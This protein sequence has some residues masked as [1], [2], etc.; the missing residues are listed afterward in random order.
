[1]KRFIVAALVGL[2]TAMVARP[3]AAQLQ[4]LPVYFNP[5]GGTGLTISGDFGRA[6][7][8]KVNDVAQTQKPV[9]IGG[10]V[11]L[12]LPLVTVGVGAAIFDPM[13]TTQLNETQYAGTAAVRVF[14]GG[15]LPVAVSVQGGAGYLKQGAGTFA[16]KTVSIP[17]GVGV[18]LN[19]PTPGA[20]VE[21]W[22]AG[23]VQLNSVTSGSASGTQLGY[24]VSGGLSLGMPIG[25]GLHVAVDWV[26][27]SAKPSSPVA[28]LRDKVQRLT[29][30]AGIHFSIKIPGLPG[31]PI[32]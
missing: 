6:V 13:I 1:M 26:S 9:A 23:R 29:A 19:L 7:S 3:A 12:G 14:G 24:G 25:L 30:G 31:I 2:G 17:L 5:K 21:P 18:A 22:V 32:L 20:S 15:L 11:R 8:T 27:L 10:S 4:G 16:T 28:Q